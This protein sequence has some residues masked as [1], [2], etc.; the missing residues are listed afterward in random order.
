[1]GIFEEGDLDVV[2]QTDGDW[3][4]GDFVKGARHS[5][6]AAVKWAFHDAHSL[7]TQK[8]AACIRATT[9]AVLIRGEFTIDF[10]NAPG[11]PSRYTV[12]M[13]KCGH[14]VV[15]GPGIPHKSESLQDD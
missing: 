14:F 11:K 2:R 12:H 1:M 7:S 13:S 3:V 5:K 8:W 6:D 15:F 4:V 10:I 9:L